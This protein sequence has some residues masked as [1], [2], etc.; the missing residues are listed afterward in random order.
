MDDLTNTSDNIITYTSKRRCRC[1]AN[2]ALIRARNVIKLNTNINTNTTITSDKR[3]SR[4]AMHQRRSTQ[5]GRETMAP[6]QDALSHERS[7]CS[8]HVTC[9]SRC[10]ISII[11]HCP[12]N[13]ATTSSTSTLCPPTAH[14][15][16]Y[17]S[18]SAVFIEACIGHSTPCSSFIS[19][20]LVRDVS[21]HLV[22]ASVRR[23]LSGRPSI[24]ATNE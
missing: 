7:K 10:S 22:A 1:K 5:N 17:A 4:S 18:S 2:T 13:T 11:C 15:P 6:K 14:I 12:A 19:N 8:T 21:A 23:P 9:Q 3:W 24:A 20:L 16:S